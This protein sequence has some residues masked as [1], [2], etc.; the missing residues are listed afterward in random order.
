VLDVLGQVLGWAEPPQALRPFRE[1][2]VTT[3]RGEIAG[4]ITSSVRLTGASGRG[5]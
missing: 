5:V 4:A 1:P 3:A 2:P